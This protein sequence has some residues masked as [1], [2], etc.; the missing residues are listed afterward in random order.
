MHEACWLHGDLRADNII[1]VEGSDQVCVGRLI[2]TYLHM[3]Y[4]GICLEFGL[5]A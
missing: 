3:S 4:F 2:M 1:L 5:K